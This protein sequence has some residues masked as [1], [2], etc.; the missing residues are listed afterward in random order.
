[1]VWASWPTG[2]L[3]AQVFNT[4]FPARGH[5]SEM[6]SFLLVALPLSSLRRLRG[7][8]NWGEGVIFLFLFI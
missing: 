4:L 7:A 5:E 8:E 2:A 6:L 3:P 1:M